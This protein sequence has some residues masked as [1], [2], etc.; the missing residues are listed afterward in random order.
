[1]RLQINLYKEDISVDYC[2][3]QS[4]LRSKFCRVFKHL[5]DVSQLE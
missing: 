4:N 5:A 1:M 3:L 2:S